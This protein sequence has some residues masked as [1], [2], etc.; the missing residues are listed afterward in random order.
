VSL[1]DVEFS[2]NELKQ[3]KVT[4]VREKG[5]KSDTCKRKITVGKLT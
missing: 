5:S 3:E 1:W 2:Q 4:L